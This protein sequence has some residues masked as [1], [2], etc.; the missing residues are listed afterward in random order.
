MALQSTGSGHVPGDPAPACSVLAAVIG[1]EVID[2]DLRI[3]VANGRPECSDHLGDFG[4]P[5]SSV[6]KRRVHHDVIEA[7]ATRTMGF[8]FLEARRLLQLD[9]L[10]LRRRWQGDRCAEEGD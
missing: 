6:R 2:D 4:L 5:Y 7:V 9:R 1:L 10:L 3:G 8:D